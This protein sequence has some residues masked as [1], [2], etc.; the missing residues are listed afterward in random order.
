M[1]D[2]STCLATISRE[3]N[4]HNGCYIMG[5]GT[6]T[7][8]VNQT[9]ISTRLTLPSI[10][11]GLVIILLSRKGL[12]VFPHTCTRRCANTYITCWILVSSG[13]LT[14]LGHRMWSWWERHLVNPDFA[15]I[16]GGST[17]AVNLM[18]STCHELM[19][20]WMLR[21]VL[22]TSPPWIWSPA[23][24]RSKWKRR[25]NSILHSLWAHLGSMECN[26]MP[27]DLN[28]VPAT[29]QRLMQHVLGDLHLNRCA[30]TSMTLSSTQ[31]RRKS[32]KVCWREFSKGSEKLA[33]S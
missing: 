24:G 25:P 5:G 22:S 16:W 33:W 23:T 21:Q 32:M 2:F 17:S 31:R 15:L 29:F 3:M 1:R 9:L 27:F 30:S 8:S 18:L 13:P 11:W 19:R 28:N 4:F 20:P 6:R 7:L 10:P 12:D 26:R 14:A